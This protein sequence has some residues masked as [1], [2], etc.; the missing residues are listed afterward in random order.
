MAKRMGDAKALIVPPSGMTR[1]ESVFEEEKNE[2]Q[3]LAST[4]T[5]L[6]TKHIVKRNE[7][8]GDIAESYGVSTHYLMKLN[9]LKSSKIKVGQKL[10][11]QSPHASK[12]HHV[13][14]QQGSTKANKR[15]VKKGN[16]KKRVANRISNKHVSKRKHS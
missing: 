12:A 13:K 4:P 3:E 5:T 2:H 15:H 7:S 11:L 8:L 6:K 1:S 9:H 10:L 16:S 14:H